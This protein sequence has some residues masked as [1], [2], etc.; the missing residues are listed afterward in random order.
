MHEATDFNFR[1]TYFH[2]FCHPFYP[3]I[4]CHLILFLFL[5]ALLPR[6]ESSSSC[7]GPDESDHDGDGLHL[8]RHVSQQRSSLLSQAS[9]LLF[10]PVRWDQ[11]YHTE[12]LLARR[13][14]QSCGPRLI[15]NIALNDFILICRPFI[16]SLHLRRRTGPSLYP[17]IP[18]VSVGPAVQWPLSTS[19]PWAVLVRGMCGL[20][21]SHPYFWRSPFRHPL[22]SFQ[23][24]AKMLAAQ[25]QCHLALE[26]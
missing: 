7:L 10:H 8:Y 6:F 25:E 11:G 4:V 13:F 22:A 19:T 12:W 5:A 16:T 15:E 26:C 2:I 18:P 3:C 14:N 24:L 21:G 9:I 23:P 20:S 1:L 17:D